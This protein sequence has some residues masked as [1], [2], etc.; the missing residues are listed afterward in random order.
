LQSCLSIVKITQMS[1]YRYLGCQCSFHSQIKRFY[2]LIL[3]RF[4]KSTC[5]NMFNNIAT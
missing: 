5:T 1:D 2:V 4:K 3:K